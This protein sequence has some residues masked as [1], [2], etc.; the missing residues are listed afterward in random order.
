MWPRSRVRKNP[1]YS[2]CYIAQSLHELCMNVRAFKDGAWVQI[3]SRPHRSSCRISVRFYFASLFIWPSIYV[4]MSVNFGYKSMGYNSMTRITNTFLSPSIPNPKY[5]KYL[6]GLLTLIIP[7]HPRRC[8][9]RNYNLNFNPACP[10]AG[11]QRY[12]CCYRGLFNVLL[13]E[14][15]YEC[16]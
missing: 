15:A 8:V 10:H 11:W 13:F 14:S 6:N 4:W 7:S 1:K 2:E 5:K 3:I 9:S 16:L 12:I